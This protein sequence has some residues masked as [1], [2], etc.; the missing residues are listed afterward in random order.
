MGTQRVLV[1]G[2]SGFV[3]R[4]LLAALLDAGYAVRAATRFAGTLPHSVD[5]VVVPDFKNA[6]D[7][8]PIL[9]GVDVVIHLAGL[10]HTDSHDS[11]YDQIN[12]TTTLDLA[13]AAKEAGVHRFVFLSSMR[14]QAGPSAMHILHEQDDPHPTDQYGRSKLAAELTVRSAGL[15]FT[16]LRPVALYGP[17]PKANVKRLV[18]LAKLPLPL[19]FAGF[20]GRRSLLGIDNLI[21]AIFFV[22]NTPATIGETFL[23]ADP[24]PLTLAEIFTMLRKALGRRP[25]LMSIPPTAIRLGLYLLGQGR[26]W[27]RISEDLVVDTS[28]LEAFGWR[29]AVETYDGFRAMLSA[30][31][32]RP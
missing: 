32:P 1:T 15:P 2:A 26:L 29:P 3:G 10:A 18:Q 22:L 24:A 14:A 31:P 21:G 12:W 17:H 28:K 5:E 8:K 19:P 23:V 9:K 20:T 27:E 4:P 30:G 25:G 6:V 11:A 16:I 7:W 13:R